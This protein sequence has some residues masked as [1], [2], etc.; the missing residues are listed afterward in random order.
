MIHTRAR[1]LA[2]G[3]LLAAVTL[4]AACGTTEPA[5]S[6]TTVS[7]APE[8][9]SGPLTF[10]DGRG[11]EVTLPDGPATRVVVLEWSQAE[12][13]VS[14]GV[15]P[16]GLADVAGYTSWVGTAAPLTNEPTDV[17][18][19]REPSI[20]TIATLEP[21]LI[22]GSVGSIPDSAM[23]QMERIAPIALMT[24]AN[25]DDPLGLMRSEF[26]T[27]ATAL[28]QED[29]A[30]KILA[31]YD[32][33]VA[34]NAQKLA[35]A[36]LEG[37]PIVLSSP[38][39]DGANVTIRM[40]GPRTTVQAVANDM[41]LT[42]AW[43]DPGDEQWGLSNIDLEGLT[44][45]P[46]NT[47]FFYWGNDTSESIDALESAALWQD[48]PFVKEDHVYRGAVGIWAYGGPVSMTAWSNDITNQLTAP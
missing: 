10:T 46:D 14:L 33:T 37:T 16:V 4:L 26:T 34:A 7:E 5:A 38:Y 9:S 11:E 20:E 35:D 25:G 36:G 23:E 2:A 3:A 24:G 22:L 32:D 42:P 15:E 21:D 19:R 18:V 8:S 43:E 17:G 29:N 13:V 31:T 6:Q 44:N 30:E 12:A 40:H 28:G 39:A 1:G 45:L 48:L 41:G 27:I 47:R